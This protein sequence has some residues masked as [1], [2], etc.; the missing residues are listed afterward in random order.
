MSLQSVGRLKS[1]LSFHVNLLHLRVGVNPSGNCE[2]HEFVNDQ[3][4]GQF[5]PPGGS[6]VTTKSRGGETH[7]ATGGCSF[8]VATSA[9]FLFSGLFETVVDKF[10]SFV[11][12][13]V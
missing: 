1:N 7:N 2:I 6:V 8:N 11:L 3:I 10:S 4:P 9:A 5:C 13:M 12:M